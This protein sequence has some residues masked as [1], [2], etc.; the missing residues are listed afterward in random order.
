ML[1]CPVQ[2]LLFGVSALLILSSC[3]LER[4]VLSDDGKPV[5]SEN[6]KSES[7]GLEEHF[8]SDF[9]AKVSSVKNKD[10]VPQTVI[11]KQSSYQGKNFLM[12]NSSFAATETKG[13][14]S[15]VN[16]KLF[17]SGDKKYK[18]EQWGGNYANEVFSKDIRPEFMNEGKGIA[19]TE[20]EDAGK[21][22]S[23]R[24]SDIAGMVYDHGGEQFDT[25]K[26]DGMIEEGIERGRHTTS[27]IKI[28]PYRVQQQRSVEDVRELL[29]RK[30]GE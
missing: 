1:P 12:Q 9:D 11:D 17:D 7:G 30:P 25:L 6:K 15:E 18:T 19:R 5:I 4:T 24:N 27:K 28:V 23:R 22:I 13:S 26:R 14:N 29:G 8:L 21:V 10:G 3:E 20:W 16:K 2:L